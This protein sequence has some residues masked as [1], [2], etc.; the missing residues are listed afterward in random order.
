MRVTVTGATGFIG[1]RVVGELLRRGHEVHAVMRSA[2]QAEAMA[3][4]DQVQ[5]VEGDVLRFGPSAYG[6]LGEPEVL[7]HL[8][9]RGLQSYKSLDH[10][11]IELPQHFAFLSSMLA[12]GLPS[13]VVTG[14]CLEYGL[15][16]GCLSE[17][18]APVPTTP[19]GFA[20]DALRKQLEFVQAERDFAFTW[21]RMFYMYGE[22]PGR[23]TLYMQIKAAVER[24]D[25]TFSMSHGEQ[26]RDYLS[27]DDAVQLLVKLALARQTMGVVNVCSGQ[28]ISVRR[29]VEGWIQ[30]NNW[31]I[32]LDLGQRPYPDYEP[33][34]FWGDTSRLRAGILNS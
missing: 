6:A 15:Q 34:A 20:K 22:C 17:R 29:L 1:R 8:A 26:L 18:L 10:I 19:Y 9:W 33:L 27:V 2:A 4:R 23:N 7:I 31:N 11:H 28:P 13:L 32:A 25:R 12:A 21:A 5:V 3:W 30:D 14:T 16:S 24:G